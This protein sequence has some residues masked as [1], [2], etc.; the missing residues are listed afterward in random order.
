M[1]NDPAI[2]PGSVSCPEMTPKY[3]DQSPT[4]NY[5]GLIR[6]IALLETRLM[7]LEEKIRWSISELEI[8]D[9]VYTR[10]QLV[11]HCQGVVDALREVLK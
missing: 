2:I 9:N 6:I 3:D 8:L 10:D 4:M 11:E 5:L 7:A 1:A